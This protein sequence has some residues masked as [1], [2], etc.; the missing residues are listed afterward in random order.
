MKGPGLER[1][2][3]GLKLTPQP[4]VKGRRLVEGSILGDSVSSIVKEASFS[5]SNMKDFRLC[6]ASV[7]VLPKDFH[8]PW[9]KVAI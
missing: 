8:L 4:P 6:L 1:G 7:S 9:P 5:S 2:R 3:A